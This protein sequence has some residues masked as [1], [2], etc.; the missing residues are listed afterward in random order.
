MAE[1]A[2]I[3]KKEKTLSKYLRKRSAS[4][5]ESDETAKFISKL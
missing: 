3:E 5:C 2:S 1:I 4:K